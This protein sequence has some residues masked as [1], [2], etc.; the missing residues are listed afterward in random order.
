MLYSHVRNLGTLLDRLFNDPSILP[1]APSTEPPPAP[2]SPEPRGSLTCGFCSA[3]LTPRGEV[4]KLS[5]RAKA[6]RDFEDDLGDARRDIAERD[7]T[8]ETLTTKLTSV[9]REL[10]ALKAEKAQKKGFWT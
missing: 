8:I 10:A 7:A 6:L 3:A 1:P 9:E 2:G 4:I 5:D